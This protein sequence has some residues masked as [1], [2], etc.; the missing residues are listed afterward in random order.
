MI[1]AGPV[2]R[3]AAQGVQTGTIRG[4]VTDQQNLP[5]P[6]V[7]V[8]ISSPALQ[9][10]DDHDRGGRHLCV[11]G[12]AGRRIRI[13]FDIARSLRQANQQRAARRQPSSRT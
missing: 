3:L 9:G 12:A 1:A 2:A 13:A 7:T 8:T 11:P 4:T 10:A 6:G 5:L